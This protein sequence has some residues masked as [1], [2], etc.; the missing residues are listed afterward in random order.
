MTA[1]AALELGLARPETRFPVETRAVLEG[2]P[3]ENA[4]GELCGGTFANAFAHSCNSVF[5]PLGVRIGAD[6]LVDAARRYGW[7]EPPT[8]AGARPSTLPEPQAIGGPLAVGATAI[9]QGKVLA[10]PLAL[11]VVAHTVATGGIRRVPTVTGGPGRARRV[12]TP[13]VAATLERMMVRVVQDGTGRRASLCPSALPARPAR[14]SS[15]TPRR[16]ASPPTPRSSRPAITPTR[17]SRPTRPCAVPA[18]RWP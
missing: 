11:A 16:R 14:P 3:L 17:G 10:T 2:V 8:L 13:A 6:R 18:W 1:T 4:N 15:R 12:T 7:G 9:G 5:A